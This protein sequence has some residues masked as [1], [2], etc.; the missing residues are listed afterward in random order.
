MLLTLPLA[1]QGETEVRPLTP[2]E[3]YGVLGRLDM[4]SARHPGI[5]M[6][7]DIPQ[8]M[9]LLSVSEAMAYRLCILMDRDTL[10]YKLLDECMDTNTEIV[11]WADAECPAQLA[12][13]QDLSP[14]MFVRGPL[15]LLQTDCL[16]ILGIS[17]IRTPDD[18]ERGLNCIA[19]QAAINGL[20]IVTGGEPGAGRVVRR[21]T[22]QNDG[23]LVCVLNGGMNAFCTESEYAQSL[24][25]GNL[26]V[27]SQTHPDARA[28]EAD[29]AERNRLIFCLSCAA[30]VAAADAKRSEAEAVRRQMCDYLYVLHHEELPQNLPLEERGFEAVSD[31]AA[32]VSA[33]RVAAW[34]GLKAQQISL[35]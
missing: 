26:L 34:T 11:T 29:T 24:V 18:V 22:L 35:F 10:L 8:I 21:R 9:R 12:A 16:G 4:D 3:Y 2:S 27:I 25:N 28:D 13:R 1:A 33:A 15:S 7:K 32:F 20:G 19:D 30:L 14:A 31:L 23:R 6:G 17:G 5:L